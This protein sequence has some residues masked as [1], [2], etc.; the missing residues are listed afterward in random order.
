MAEGFQEHSNDTIFK[1]AVEALHRGDKA[2]AKDLLTRLLKTDQ[3]NAEYWVWL[4]ATVDAPKERV[5]CLQTALKL[6]PANVA[7]KRGLILLGAL[8]P[9]ENIQPFPMNQS[10]AWEAQLMLA[11]E[12][13]REKIGVRTIVRHPV[14]RLVAIGLIVIGLCAAV[15]FGFVLPRRLNIRAA[16][17]ITPGPS[18]TFTAT[19]TL[20]GATAVPTRLN[21]GPTPLSAFLAQTY[22]P[23]ALYVNTPRSLDTVDQYRIAQDAYKKGDWD[24]FI[25]NMELIKDIETDSADVSYY[26]GEAYRFKGE[27]SAAISAYN[28]ALDQDPNFG[29]PYLGLARVRLMENPGFNAE[30]LFQNAIKLDPYFGEV[31]LERARFYTRRGDYEDALADL[32]TAEELLPGSPSVY[33]GYAE[34]YVESGDIDSALEY[35]QKAYAADITDYETYKLLGDLY[36]DKE[37]YLKALE[38]LQVYTTYVPDSATGFAKLGQAYYQLGEYQNAVN[39]IDKATELNRNG[40]RSYY[41]YRGLSHLELGNANEAVDDL[42]VA[43]NEDDRSFAARLGFARAYYLDEKFGSAFLQIDVARALA[44]TDEEKAL[45]LYWRARIQEKRED[46]ED[47]IASWK[48]LLEFDADT[49]TKE[50]RSEAQGRLKVLVP[51]TR[52]PK[53][54]APTSTPKPAT[55][56]PKPG[57]S[58]TPSRT[59]GKTPSPTPTP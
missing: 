57:T 38:V 14:L 8:T 45:T 5:Y 34:T 23:T 12:K 51:P 46:I 39:A 6:D 27:P 52:T 56:T 32:K 55:S 59:P 17:T 15:L 31:Y 41:V 54:G 47:A 36:I 37:D 24:T 49:M 11:S 10:R 19:P 25:L 30:S 40:L 20:F 42:E 22:T 26:I 1:D 4:S 35:A 48:A 3:N 43:V 16:D 28:E 2:R 50:M 53:G 21:S 44:E 9:E 58:P 13:P 7:A 29:P 33:R 18:P